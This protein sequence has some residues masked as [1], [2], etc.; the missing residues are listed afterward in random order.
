MI[1]YADE[2]PEDRDVCEDQMP[3]GTVALANGRLAPQDGMRELAIRLRTDWA[4]RGA[5]GE[6]VDRGQDRGSLTFWHG[7]PVRV[8][9]ATIEIRGGRIQDT[10][11]SANGTSLHVLVGVGPE[12]RILTYRRPWAEPRQRPRVTD[13]TA[14]IV[15]FGPAAVGGRWIAV[16]GQGRLDGRNA[17]ILDL[18]SGEVR[19]LDDPGMFQGWDDP[20]EG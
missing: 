12:A 6:L 7:C 2:V 4:R 3:V 9:R 18:H 15:G 11:W 13:P 19:W 10:R 8:S 16:R 20:P 14:V 1:M 5:T 17:G